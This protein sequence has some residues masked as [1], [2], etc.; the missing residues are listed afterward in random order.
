MRKDIFLEEAVLDDL[1]EDFDLLEV[2][3]SE[4]AF[5][6]VGILAAVIISVV[7]LRIIFLGAVKGNFYKNRALLNASQ[8][9]PI[10]AERGIIFDRFGE[11][12]VKNEP[13]YR[14]SLRLAE[15]MKKEWRLK[16]LA[17]VSDILGISGKE[18][19]TLINSFD[20]E[21]QDIA[22]LAPQLN[23]EQ[24]EK[25]QKLNLK[26]VIIKKDFKR[27]Y[28]DSEIFSH[29]IGYVGSLTKEDIKD[30]LSLND[31]I[32]KSGL[33]RYYDGRLR[34]KDGQIINYRNAKGEIID[35]KFLNAAEAGADIKTTI[36]AEFQI[37][38]FNQL[39]KRLGELGSRNGVGIAIDPRSG[40][41]LALV[42]LPSFDGNNI[43]LKSLND[44]ERPFFN[45][46]ISGLYVPG[47]T[48]KPLVAFAALKEGVIEPKT[49][50]FSRGYIEVPNPYFPDQPSRFVDWKPQGWVNLYSALARSSN[51]YFYALGGGLPDSE[52]NLLRNPKNEFNGLGIKKLKTYWQMFGLDEKTGVDLSYEASGFLP[53]PGLKEER[54]KGQWRIGD[55]YNVAIGQGDLL[56]TPMEI[57][58]FISGIAEDGKF[59]RPFI[60]KEIIGG[61]TGAV[62][63][64]AP[65]IARD[66]S[67]DADYFKEVQKGMIDVIAKPYG[68]ANYLSDLPMKVAGKTGTAQTKNKTRINAFFTGF[69]PA[70]N[71][72]IAVLVL[73]ENAEEGS[74]NSLPVAKEVLR[75]YYNNRIMNKE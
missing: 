16:T 44:P 19:E 61:K 35:E 10:S 65:L 57:I 26:P 9:I 55:T 13:V 43:A 67:G 50:I 39:K 3:L 7:F 75:W 69:A 62:Y 63:E 36:D 12:L 6:L 24:A 8:I 73:I 54:G 47:S 49:E 17:A 41:I 23:E 52:L 56:A 72:Q 48:I 40:E 4:R 21:K 74:S 2:P 42:S 18:T 53:D 20:L 45:R 5:K 46:A 58:N 31:I 51:V 32:G 28:Q 59:Y 30:N 38:F 29:I 33:E 34:G 68:T 37:Y 27:K 22:T 71:P 60:V 70:E 14:V 25:F 15:L 1:A 66:Y 11:P 64:T